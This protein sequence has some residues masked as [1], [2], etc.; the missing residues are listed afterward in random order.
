MK[1]IITRIEKLE[2]PYSTSRLGMK[3]TKED[4][5]RSD[6]IVALMDEYEEITRKPELFLVFLKF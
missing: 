3:W 1:D 2:Q 6:E 4:Q 5:K